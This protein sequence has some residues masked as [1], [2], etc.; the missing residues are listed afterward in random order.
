MKPGPHQPLAHL[1]LA[2]GLVRASPCVYTAFAHAFGPARAGPWPRSV[3]LA[4]PRASPWAAAHQPFG[5]P[6]ASPWPPLAR[7]P[8]FARRVDT[9]SWC[10]RDMPRQSHKLKPMLLVLPQPSPR[11]R[12]SQLF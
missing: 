12:K 7:T 2:L 1:A 5:L 10:G 4:P 11:Q 8:L 6:R 3:P 9:P